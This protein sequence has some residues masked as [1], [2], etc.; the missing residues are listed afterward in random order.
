LAFISLK[1]QKLT[2]NGRYLKALKKENQKSRPRESLNWAGALESFWAFSVVFGHFRR[3]SQ[4]LASFLKF[5]EILYG[6]REFY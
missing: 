5:W 3:F 6:F 2:K 1:L 4:V